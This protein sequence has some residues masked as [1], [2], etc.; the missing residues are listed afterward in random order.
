M[1]YAWR[2]VNGKWRRRRTGFTDRRQAIVI[3]KQWH[4]QGEI[5]ESDGNVTADFAAM[6]LALHIDQ[7]VKEDRENPRQLSGEHIERKLEGLRMMVRLG[8]WQRLKHITLESAQ[9]VLQ[10]IRERKHLPVAVEMRREARKASGDEPNRRGHPPATP[11]RMR[12]KRPDETA[13]TTLN[14][15]RAYL[16][17]FTRWAEK[18]G[19][20]RNDPLKAL[21]R[22][23]TQGA[24]RVRRRAMTLEECDRLVRA[25]HEGPK[26]A[27]IDGPDRAMLYRFALATGFRKAECAAVTPADFV[28]AGPRPLV[29]LGG[30]HTK[31]RKTV[32]QPFARNLAPMFETWLAGRERSKPCWPGLKSLAASKA[33]AAD[34]AAAGLKTVTED[35]K[36]DFHALR[37]SFI[38]M[39]AMGGVEIAVAQR[40]ARHQNYQLTAQ[41]YTHLGLSDTGKALDDV[42]YGSKVAGTLSSICAIGGGEAWRRTAQDGEERNSPDQGPNATPVGVERENEGKTSMKREWDG[43]DSNRRRGD[44]ESPASDSKSLSEQDPIAQAQ[45]VGQTLCNPRHD[46]PDLSNSRRRSARER[47]ESGDVP[48]LDEALGRI[49]ELGSMARTGG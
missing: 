27:G 25:A 36:V 19:R 31:N 48:N 29:R 8:G 24:E 35:G 26:R 16:K 28:F 21:H 44:Y 49:R 23:R 46:A 43:S 4:D 5:D 3:A 32:N 39:L 45:Y 37:H 17:H 14:L 10:M 12:T 33:V 9:G 1:W 11:K 18:N 22:F 41:V 30:T 42:G 34:M 47:A 38:T 20:I 15:Y 40:L 6:P 13:P 7:W 2:F